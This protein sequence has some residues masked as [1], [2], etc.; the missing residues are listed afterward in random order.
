MK[1][2]KMKYETFSE[3]LQSL[4]CSKL[5]Q[6]TQIKIFPVLKN[7]S[8]HL[9]GLI[10]CQKDNP[11]SPNFYLQDLYQQYLKGNSVNALV[12]EIIGCWKKTLK[13]KWGRNLD[14]SFEGCRRKIV[15]RLVSASRNKELLE[16]IP[17]IPFLDLAVVFYC[18]VNQDEEGIGS[19]RISNEL[20][21]KWNVSTVD[22]M[23]EATRNTPVLFP[24][25]CNPMSS[26]LESMIF[27]MKE[28]ERQEYVRSEPYVLTNSNGI[29]GASVW[30][31]PNQLKNMADFFGKSFYILPSSIHE[32]LLIA[33]SY[34]STEEELISMVREVNGSCV[35]QDEILSDNIYYYDK[36][37]EAVRVITAE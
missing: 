18:L 5:P 37:K 24:P 1:V 32:V 35:E 7:N 6:G 4:L 30:L 2:V 27:H 13:Q 17:H 9:D 19:I 15:Y 33:E 28:E 3:E 34:D 14:L 36:K 26:I 21:E 29:N 11:L 23:T 8:L 12:D 16:D 20:M 10:I 31:Y 25:K 22:L